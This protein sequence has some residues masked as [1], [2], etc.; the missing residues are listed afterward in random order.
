[1]AGFDDPF[2]PMPDAWWQL[3]ATV[4]LVVRYRHASW[5][6]SIGGWRLPPSSTRL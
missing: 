2:A 1:M 3:P 4:T 5:A 6:T